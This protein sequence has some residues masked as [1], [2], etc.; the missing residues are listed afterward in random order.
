MLADDWQTAGGAVFI[1]V[2]SHRVAA[3]FGSM[4]VLAGHW[5]IDTKETMVKWKKGILR[6]LAL[7]S[8]LLMGCAPAVAEDLG[9]IAEKAE[10]IKI[11]SMQDYIDNLYKN[12]V[13][14]HTFT[15]NGDEI[16]C[17]D[18]QTQPALF[19]P[20]MLGRAVDV[21]PSLDDTPPKEPSAKRPAMESAA[22][23]AAVERRDKDSSVFLT[24]GLD[25]YGREMSCPENSVPILPVTLDRMKRFKSVEEFLQKNPPGSIPS[26]KATSDQTSATYVHKYAH[27]YKVADNWGQEATFNIWSPYC[28]TPGEFSLS[29][30]W[31]VRGSGSNLETVEAGWQNYAQKYG[32]YNSRL[33]IYFTPDNYGPGGCYNNDCGKFVQTNNSI[34]L[35][36]K[37]A[38]YSKYGGT[39]W[40]TTI[41]WQRKSSTGNWW[42]MVGGKWVGY[43]PKS[44]FDSYGLR[45]KAAVVDWGGEILDTLDSRQTKTDMGSGKFPSA[46]FKQAA[47]TRNIRYIT[48]SNT[49]ATP[50][51]TTSRTNPKCYDIS[52]TRSTDSW[53]TYFY[54]GGSGYNSQCTSQ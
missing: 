35:G 19:R 24:G 31:V 53:K 14:V 18:T 32:D 16:T 28:E 39:Q 47:Y 1:A 17:I 34:V 37:F 6:P 21:P 29:Q 26:H 27:T 48:P 46:G 22:N 5:P 50:T 38:G 51:L 7:A 8:L 52:V 10:A 3:S 12:V 4:P 36:G 41:R 54:F 40:V 2:S 43:Y 49:W 25:P 44:L 30:T 42:L 45:N 15:K 9:A 23:E 11:K 13:V 20:E 33:F